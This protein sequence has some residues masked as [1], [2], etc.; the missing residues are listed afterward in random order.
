[1]LFMVVY[2]WDKDNRDEIIKRR[3]EKG[4]MFPSG[5]KILSEYTAVGRNVHFGLVEVDDPKLL[6]EGTIAWNDIMDVDPHL[7]L[8]TQKDLLGLLKG[9]V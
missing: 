1:M 7:V 4:T 8:D 5:A 3:L 9:V 6:T 2:S